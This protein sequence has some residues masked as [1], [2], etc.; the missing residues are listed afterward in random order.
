MD[1]HY[2]TLGISK[3]ATQEEIKKAYRKLA[4]QHHPD[5]GG[6]TATF[7]KIQTA[8]ATLSDDQKRA[9]YDNP[10][11]FANQQFNGG[12]F[13][14]FDEILRNHFGGHS[15]FGGGFGDVFGQ[16]RPQPRTN[17]NLNLRTQITLEDAFTGKEVYAELK[18]HD[19]TTKTVEIKIPPGIGH[20][21]TLRVSGAGDHTHKQLAP[22]DLMLEIIILPH[23]KFLRNG[24]DLY[25]EFN[26]DAWEA[27]LGVEKDFTCIDGTALKVLIPTG[28]QPGQTIRLPSRG[29]SVLHQNSR[30]HQY[31]NIKILIPKNLTDEQK[32]FV[33]TFL[34]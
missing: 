16:R 24:D 28:I 23:Q 12:G 20:G 34:P 30:G 8:Y 15:P 10:N 19:G 26:I 14:S 13:H 7:Q 18:N 25:S 21:Q 31:L 29:M 17:Q 32:D 5:K 4:S 9:E 33:K 6:D 2:Q 27:M 11:P 3:S 22:G 1:D